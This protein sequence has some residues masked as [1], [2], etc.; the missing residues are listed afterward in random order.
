MP[1]MKPITLTLQ[2]WQVRMI[3]DHL[4]KPFELTMVRRV[5]ISFI[6]KKQWVM[7]RQPVRADLLRGAWN[8]YLTDAQIKRVAR[9]MG[10]EMQISALRISPSMVKSGAI[11]FE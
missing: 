3:G 10:T 11:V 7:Y 6:D 8:L 2:P 9:A 4:R 1:D 5:K